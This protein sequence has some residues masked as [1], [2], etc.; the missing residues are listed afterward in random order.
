MRGHFLHLHSAC[1]LRLYFW[2]VSPGNQTARAAV[3]QSCY[4]AFT[5]SKLGGITRKVMEKISRTHTT[6]MA[7]NEHASYK[8]RQDISGTLFM[9]EQQSA[10]LTGNGTEE[11]LSLVHSWLG[12]LLYVAVQRIKRLPRGSVAYQELRQNTLRLICRARRAL[13]NVW[14]RYVDTKRIGFK[15]PELWAFRTGFDEAELFAGHT[16]RSEMRAAFAYATEMCKTKGFKII[17]GA[18]QC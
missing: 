2:R 9:R 12:H 6:T 7:I 13:V 10:L 18:Y 15:G 16:S 3:K 5:K 14:R 11:H 8:A 4:R 17:E 1:K